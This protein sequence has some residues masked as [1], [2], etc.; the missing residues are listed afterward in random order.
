MRFTLSRLS[1]QL[2]EAA[3]RILP[4]SAPQF[5]SYPQPPAR[6]LMFRLFFRLY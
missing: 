5:R 4:A 2:S 1:H 6:V 3:L